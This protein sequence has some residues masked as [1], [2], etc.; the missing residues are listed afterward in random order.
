MDRYLARIDIAGP[1]DPRHDPPPRRANT[2]EPLPGDVGAHGEF[3]DEAHGHSPQARL[4][5]HRGAVLTG[6]F[7]LAGTAASL[8]RRGRRQRLGRV[9]TG[10]CNGRSATT[11]GPADARRVTRAG[12]ACVVNRLVLP[13]PG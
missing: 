5:R 1:Q 10:P 11:R 7:A 3:D 6:G 13:R 4:T 2:W 12:S 9:R 8:T